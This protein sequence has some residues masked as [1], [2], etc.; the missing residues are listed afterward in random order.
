MSSAP[1][2]HRCQIQAC[3]SGPSREAGLPCTVV[4]VVPPGL[5]FKGLYIRAARPHMQMHYQEAVACKPVLVLCCPVM[6]SCPHAQADITDML[7]SPA[8]CMQAA[9]RGSRP[10]PAVLVFSVSCFFYDHR[11]L[12]G[13]CQGTPGPWHGSSSCP[14]QKGL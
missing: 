8:P 4:C 11:V 9:W 12:S 14:R 2:W 13:H 1:C 5:H 6:A 10:P 3:G 7:P